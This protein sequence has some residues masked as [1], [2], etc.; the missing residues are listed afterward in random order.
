MNTTID[1][2]LLQKYFHI[3]TNHAEAPAL[4]F[5]ATEMLNPERID[6]ILSTGATSYKAMSLELPASFLGVSLFGFTAAQLLIAAQY[7]LWLDLSLENIT[8]ELV[9]HEERV[10]TSYRIDNLHTERIPNDQSTR[11]AFLKERLENTITTTIRP[12][13]ELIAQRANHKPHMIWQQFGSRQC[14][15]LDF[16]EKNETRAI[17]RE[18]FKQ[19]SDILLNLPAELFGLRKNPY[20]HKARYIPSPRKENEQLIIRSSCCMY[21]KRENGKKCYVCPL[22]TDEQRQQRKEEQRT[23]RK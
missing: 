2:T 12:L 15:V 16:I 19:G 20:V 6:T 8:F 10:H 21:Y 5:P 9:Q 4:S 22:L 13:I 3:S 7:D 11:Q 14:F 23:Q 1:F 18:Q 17:V